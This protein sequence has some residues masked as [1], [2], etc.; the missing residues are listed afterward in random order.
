[1]S[2]HLLHL[3]SMNEGYLIM[4]LQCVTPRDCE[5]AVDH[6]DERWCAFADWFDNVGFEM[7][8]DTAEHPFPDD[9]RFPVRVKPHNWDADG[10]E[11]IYDAPE[12]D[13]A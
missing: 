3:E 4:S 8:T 2:E 10:P 6:Q 9:P 12:D 5:Y 13:D 7:L 11:V 1:M